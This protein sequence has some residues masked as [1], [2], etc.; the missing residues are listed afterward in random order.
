[1]ERASSS[2]GLSITPMSVSSFELM[3]LER[4]RKICV[5]GCAVTVSGFP[6]SAIVVM[7]IQLGSHLKVFIIH[8]YRH[9]N[10]RLNVRSTWDP[11]TYPMTLL[12]Q[13]RGFAFM[14][15]YITWSISVWSLFCFIAIVNTLGILY[16]ILVFLALFFN[17]LVRHL[18]T[19]YNVCDFHALTFAIPAFLLSAGL[20]I[21]FK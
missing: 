14:N 20:L 2:C 1:M 19:L 7:Q 5:F 12:I 18:F 15:H 4:L 6:I 8:I 3:S 21:Q 13:S 17:F 9:C 11:T 10:H 16:Y